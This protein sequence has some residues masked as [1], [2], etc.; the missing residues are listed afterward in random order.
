MPVYLLRRWQQHRRHCWHRDLVF[1]IHR[2]CC[3]S[4]RRE[5]SS[6]TSKPSPSSSSS[7][8]PTAANSHQQV[9][10]SFID[11]FVHQHGHTFIRSSPVRP[12]A[13]DTSLLF[14]NAGMNQF[15]PIFLSQSEEQVPAQFRGLKRAV[16]S[17][18]C[19]RV[20]GK[21]CDLEAVGIDNTHHTFFE[22]L[23]NWSFND[24]FKVR[25]QFLWGVLF[26]NSH[27]FVL[28]KRPARWPGPS[29]PR[30]TASTPPA[31]W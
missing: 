1:P 18:K 12:P 9:R 13:D 14:T 5:S 6:F 28:R 2:L 26:L 15:K 30:S 3:S 23:G 4:F 29:S 19:I 22:M 20:G 31:W 17:Q 10:Q 7:P 21:H 25:F 24:Y 11:Y 16:N 8:S 27:L